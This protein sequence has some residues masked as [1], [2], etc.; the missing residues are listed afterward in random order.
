MNIESQRLDCQIGAKIS[1]ARTVAG[2]SAAQLSERLGISLSELEAIEKGRARIAAPDI[3]DLATA[4]NVEIRWFFEGMR[5]ASVIDGDDNMFTCFD[6]ARASD[7]L[8]RLIRA[9]TV[10]DPPQP[11][12]SKAA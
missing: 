3:C 8:I 11:P 1:A 7:A 2:L 6:K 5:S 4:L 12:Q 10:G 9:S